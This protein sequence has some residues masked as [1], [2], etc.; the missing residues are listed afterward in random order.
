MPNQAAGAS[1]EPGKYL[2][3]RDLVIAAPRE[4]VFRYFTDSAR[5][6]SWWGLGSTIEPRAGAPYLIRYPNG[7][8][9]SGAVVEILAP[10]RLVLSFGYDD[11]SKPIPPGGS[12]VIITLDEQPRGTLLKLRHHVDTEAIREMHVPGWRYQLAV[13]AKVV[14]TA[15]FEGA[16]EKIDNYY[17]AWSVSDANER[18]SL[19]ESCA[20]PA[21]SFA[22]GFGCTSGIDDLL[23]HIA[24]CS[25]HFPG[26][27]LRAASAPRMTH[28]TAISDWEAVIGEKAVMKGSNVFEFEP[29]GAIARVVGIASA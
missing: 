8:T 9:A 5:W 3:E 4:V 21:I 18:K 12:K 1:H 11:P 24:A 25:M 17:K 27:V 15:N 22:D 2:V 10:E 14:T 28:A 29:G 13:F 7:A 6:A 16:K 26:V 20:A 23:G 19:L